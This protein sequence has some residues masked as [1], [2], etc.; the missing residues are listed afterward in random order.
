MGLILLNIVCTLGVADGFSLGTPT[1][2]SVIADT[3]YDH[4]LF[5]SKDIQAKS[6]FDWQVVDNA[7]KKQVMLTE[8]TYANFVCPTGWYK[9]GGAL[10]E[11]L[12]K[13]F[14]T[15][16]TKK[17]I[18]GYLPQIPSPSVTHINLHKKITVTY[19]ETLG[20]PRIVNNIGI[21]FMVVDKRR[22]PIMFDGKDDI[23]ITSGKNTYSGYVYYAPSVYGAGNIV[24]STSVCVKYPVSTTTTLPTTSTTMM[25]SETAVH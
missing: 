14:E 21:D 17:S 10:T 9:I 7:G 12:Y 6:P 5:L 2:T 20:T 1:E 18:R 13:S 4:E 22:A 19:Q 15:T 8:K 3:V 25:H 11:R 16:E 24:S 23:S